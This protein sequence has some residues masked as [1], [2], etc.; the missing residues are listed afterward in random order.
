M[1]KQIVVIV[2]SA[3]VILGTATTLFAAGQAT[4]SYP[5]VAGGAGGYPGS[6]EYQTPSGKTVKLRT[7]KIRGHTMIVVPMEMS[8]D[9]FRFAC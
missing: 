9:V 4:G 3:V 7:M 5:P 8:C 1:T 6:I 2:L